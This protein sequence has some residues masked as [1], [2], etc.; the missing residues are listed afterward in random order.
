[1]SGSQKEFPNF[2]RESAYRPV[3]LNFVRRRLE[4][5]NTHCLNGFGHSLLV[6]H[7]R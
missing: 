2:E 7:V 5:T 4:L 3:V 6:G 1:M